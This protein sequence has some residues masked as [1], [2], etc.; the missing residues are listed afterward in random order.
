[1]KC[2]S[3]VKF[4]PAKKKGSGEPYQKAV[5]IYPRYQIKLGTFTPDPDMVEC[6]GFLKVT[7]EASMEGE[8]S[9]SSYSVLNIKYR[10]DKCGGEYYPELPQ[11]SKELSE[12]FEAILRNLHEDDRERTL[13]VKVEKEIERQKEVEKSIKETEAK[14]QKFLESRKKKKK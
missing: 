11:N 9:C 13:I 3:M 8:C 7:V 2:K 6:N 14:Y 1:M 5:K 4:V 12:F 10:C